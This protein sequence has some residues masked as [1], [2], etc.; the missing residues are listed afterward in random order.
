MARLLIKTNLVP[1]TALNGGVGF[2]LSE[3][4]C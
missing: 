3:C 1:L 2:A 4:A